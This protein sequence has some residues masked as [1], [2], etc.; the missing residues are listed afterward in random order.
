VDHRVNE[1]NRVPVVT[2]VHPVQLDL[3]VIQ[4]QQGN[5]DQQDLWEPQVLKDHK[6]Q[7]VMLVLQDLWVPVGSLVHKGKEV[8]LEL[9]GYLEQVESKDHRVLQDLWVHQD[10]Q[11]Q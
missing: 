5:K 10:Q 6:G 1:V 9:L 2:M 4:A 11:V 8:T 3:E 7:K